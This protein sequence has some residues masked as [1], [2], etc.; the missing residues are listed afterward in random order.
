MRTS[1]LACSLLALAIV[2]AGAGAGVLSA[3]GNATTANLVIVSDRYVGGVR[4]LADLGRASSVF[5]MPDTTRRV[6]N[7]ECR[8]VWRP[9][10]L[11]L[12]FLDLS[13]GDPPVALEEWL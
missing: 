11:T 2:L 7:Y 9:V 1:K 10:G 8:A 4:V 12:G 6:S 13:G 5:G 3:N